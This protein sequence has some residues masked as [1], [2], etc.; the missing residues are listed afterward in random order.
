MER[1]AARPD[2]ALIVE[3]QYQGR[4]PITNEDLPDFGSVFVGLRLPV[5]AWRKQNRLTDAAR[6]DSAAAAA[7]LHETEVQLARDVAETAA[8]AEAARRRLELLVDGVLP[9]ARAT[10]ES[11]I[12]AIRWG[13]RSS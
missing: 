6:A 4:V 10:V 8:R 5:W 12:G 2:L 3:Y 7:S 1:L 13:A 11:V 9:A